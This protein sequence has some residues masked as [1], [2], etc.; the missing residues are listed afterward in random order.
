MFSSFFLRS[1][2]VLHDLFSK[3]RRPNTGFSFLVCGDIQ[4]FYTDVTPN[5]LPRRLSCALL[6]SLLRA[7]VG[8]SC[9]CFI[10]PVL[11][12]ICFTQWRLCMMSTVTMQDFLHCV[13]VSR[14]VIAV[15]QGQLPPQG[16]KGGIFLN[17]V[18][19]F[20]VPT[21]HCVV[22]ILSK[23]TL[24]MMMMMTTVAAVF[25]SLLCCLQSG[26]HTI[27]LHSTIVTF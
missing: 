18:W 23:E 21:Q 2:F 7:L 19:R 11:S 27:H 25:M 14:G 4:I 20:C 6:F 13:V 9:I 1:S 17:P 10:S 24:Q 15:G 12:P 3:L 22:F 16:L 5:I 26:I 8:S